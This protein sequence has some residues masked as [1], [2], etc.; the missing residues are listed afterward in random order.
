VSEDPWQYA[1]YDGAEKLQ[2]ELARKL[3]LSERLDLLDEMFRFANGL[4][5]RPSVAEEL[6]QYGS[7]SE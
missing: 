4:K 2:H 7:D 3:S 6:S 1:T 5:E